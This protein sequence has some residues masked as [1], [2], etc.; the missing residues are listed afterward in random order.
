[1]NQDMQ[2]RRWCFGRAIWVMTLFAVTITSLQG[3]VPV[4]P[5]VA[6]AGADRTVRCPDGIILDGTASSSY[7]GE[8]LRFSWAQISGP[9]DAK[10]INANAMTAS[11]D[12]LMPGT[13]EFVLTVSNDLGSDEA[14]VRITVLEAGM[15]EFDCTEGDPPVDEPDPPAQPTPTP[16]PV[17]SDEVL[18]ESNFSTG[19]EDWTL[20]SNGR[21]TEP[22]W[23]SA[24]GQIEKFFNIGSGVGY[25]VAPREYY[26]DFSDAFGGTLRF[27]LGSS[28]VTNK[29]S[30][31]VIITSPLGELTFG[32]NEQ[33]GRG[34]KAY[35][36]LLDSRTSWMLQGENRLATDEEIMMILEVMAGLE[37]RGDFQANSA[38]ARGWLDN[39]QILRPGRFRR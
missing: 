24:E 31:L 27:D 3:C 10:V 37:I 25:F 23:N 17:P 14:R 30:P 39:V 15:G 16:T 29:P 5:P 12:A 33:P 11:F 1:M 32:N 36:L 35:T 19:S 7:G 4:L 2:I 18:V 34:E 38:R 22:T 13:F 20:R 8:S 9:A 6:D 21:F 28:F 26:G